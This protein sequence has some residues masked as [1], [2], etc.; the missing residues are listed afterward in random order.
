MF[1]KS[2]AS[3][4]YF[5]SRT[6]ECL[7]DVLFEMGKD[8]FGKK[9]YTMSVK[10]LERAYE[11]LHGQELDK[12]SMD[13]SELRIS[14]IQMTVKALLALDTPETTEKS[15]GL[16]ELLESE[17]GDKLVVLLLKLEMLTSLTNA[18]FDSKAYY[19]VLQR[20]VRTL[21]LIESNFR[22]IMFHIRKLNDKSPSLAAKSLEDFLNSRLLDQAKEEWIE[23]AIITYLWIMVSRREDVDVLQPLS[24]SSLL[25]ELTHPLRP[26]A[27]HAAH[28][29][30]LFHRKGKPRINLVQY[31]GALE[32]N[33]IKLYTRTL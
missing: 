6:A 31:L 23:K 29:V 20:M 13:A 7:A 9:Q 10:W 17:V 30:C 14:I 21:S 26:A 33:R 25:S 11:V 3:E 15:K 32:E 24:I 28:M 5:D 8:L 18:S 16:I 19:D 4:Q 27:A 1:K 12:L 2:L 22:L